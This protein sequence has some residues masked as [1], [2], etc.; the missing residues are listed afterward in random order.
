MRKLLLSLLLA[1]SFS[2]VFAQKLDDIQEKIEKKKF[3][4]AKEKLDKVL[5]DPKHQ[6]NADAH[7]FKAVIHYNMSLENPA[8]LPVALE[9]MK[10]YFELEQAKEESKR[11]LRS[12]FEGHKTA[13]AIYS[14]YFRSGVKN[15]QEKK[16]L[17]AVTAFDGAIASFELLSNNK[18]TDVKFDTTANIYAG[19]AAQNAQKPEIA[20][21]Y[22]DKLIT[23][24]IFDTT[25]LD[26][27]RYMIN[28]HLE[29]TKDT[30]EALRYLQIN[31]TAFPAYEDLWVDYEM[32]AMSP[33]REKKLASYETLVKKYPNNFVAALNHGVE[34]Y[35]YTF[36]S[37][38]KPANYVESQETTKAALERAIALNP[39]S[40]HATYIMSQFYVNRIYDV[41][42]SVRNIKGTTAADVAKK[43]ELNARMDQHYENM[44]TYTQQAYDNFVKD[45]A[46]LKAQDKAN[47]RRVINQ[48]I[49]YYTRKKQN[50]KVTFYQDK[51]KQLK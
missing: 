22:Y 21:K 43:K 35:N 7:F 28:Y 38:P 23:N 51:L 6:N 18:L 37:D 12:T 45:E 50:D 8:E 26:A 15:F 42:D 27:Y 16:Y 10:K 19:F 1:A 48:M 40:H 33:I 17:D 24:N 47:Y 5:A 31:E 34:L 11:M 13:F 3:G 49:D 44:Y 20:V 25:Y 9:A 2:G 30:A 4:E 29:N 36:F 41:E 39:G 32:G 46:T 14:D